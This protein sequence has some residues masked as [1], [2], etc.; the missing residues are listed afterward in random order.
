MLRA[1]GDDNPITPPYVE[2]EMTPVRWFVFRQFEAIVGPWWVVLAA[3][4]A[5]T[6]HIFG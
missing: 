5:F 6:T 3:A 1:C 4:L 2:I